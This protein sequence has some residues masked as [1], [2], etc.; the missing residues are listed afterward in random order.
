M[1]KASTLIEM[2]AV[3]SILV[4]LIV[5]CAKPLDTLISGIPRASRDFQ[6]NS[7]MLGMLRE[8]R[9][10]IEGSN[11]LLEYATDETIGNNMLLIETEGGI[12]CYELGDGEVAKTTSWVDEQ[13]SQDSRTWSLPR[14]KISWKLRDHN[15]KKCAVELTTNIER[16]VMGKQEEKLRNSYV[17]FAGSG[18]KGISQ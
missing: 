11:G 14:V 6:T 18:G 7:V 1:R 12:V 9:G 8:L 17:Y 2:L 4:M 13:L 16:M 15:G 5:A 10:D 3:I